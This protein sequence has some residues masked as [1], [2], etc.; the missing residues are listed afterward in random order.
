VKFMTQPPTE[1]RLA[2]AGRRRGRRCSNY[3]EGELA[4]R[5]VLAGGRFGSP[6]TGGHL[7]A[8]R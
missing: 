8:S 3:L 2:N 7:L 6:T 4:D 5:E 1:A